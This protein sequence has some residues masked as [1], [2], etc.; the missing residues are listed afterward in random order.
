MTFDNEQELYKVAEAH[1]SP[2]M[3]LR[4][5]VDDS[6]S[7]CKFS[8]KFGASIEDA[9]HLLLTA[10]SLNLSVIGVSFH[11]GSGCESTESFDLAIRDAR[12]VFDLV[13]ELGMPPMTLLDLGGG[14]PGT[15]SALVSFDA[16]TQTVRQSLDEYFSETQFPDVKIIAEPGRYYAASAFTLATM[17]I[18]KRMIQLTHGERLAMYYL[19]DGVYGSFNCTVFDHAIVEPVPLDQNLNDNVNTLTNST[20]WGPTCDSM[21]LIKKDVLINE[22]QVGDWV[23]FREMGAYTIA[24]A[25]NFNGF[26]IPSMKFFVPHHTLDSLMHLPRWPALSHVLELDDD[27]TT[28]S[29]GSNVF[30]RNRSHHDLNG[31]HDGNNVD[32]HYNES[33]SECSESPCTYT[34]SDSESGEDVD[35]FNIDYD[36]D[37]LMAFVH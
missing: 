31:N 14:W 29:T 11:V 3:V 25:S 4:I 9:R 2:K 18:A 28:P 23:V 19:N 26:A 24:A 1:E 10:K 21:D 16:M 36:G 5:K 12:Y 30:W 22:L 7:I 34:C 15:S 8:A 35:D 17:V 6:H 33:A 20:F 27:N 13:N 32:E 37:A